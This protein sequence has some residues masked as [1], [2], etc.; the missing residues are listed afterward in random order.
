MVLWGS[1]HRGTV[2]NESNSEPWGCGFDH[3]PCSVGWGSGIAVSCGVGCRRSLDHTLLWLWHRL[4]ATAPIGPLAWEPPY[5]AGAAQEMPKRPKKKKKQNKGKKK[6]K[7]L[8]LLINLEYPNI[9]N[10]YTSFVKERSM[11]Y[12]ILLNF[13]KHPLPPYALIT[14]PHWSLLFLEYTNYTLISRSVHHL[15]T[16]MKQSYTW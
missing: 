1:P 8:Y 5:S 2:V 13:Q 11:D 7:I 3:W 15:A 9:A 6:K 16:Y 12:W 4:V 14:Q 10:V